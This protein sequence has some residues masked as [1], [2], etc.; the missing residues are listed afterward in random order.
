MTTKVSLKVK[1]PHCNKSLMDYNKELND[2]PSIK[3]NIINTAGDRGSIWLCSTYGCYDKVCNID[4]KDG[5][6]VRLSC[7]H[8]E[9]E[10]TVGDIEAGPCCPFCDKYLDMEYDEDGELI[11]K[12]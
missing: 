3:A 9:E 5:T 11:Y 10:F 6:R 2:K 1:C 7:P 8:C 12:D 4:L